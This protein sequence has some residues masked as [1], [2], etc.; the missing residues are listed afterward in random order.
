MEP[1]LIFEAKLKCPVCGNETLIARDY[2]YDAGEVGKL[3][4]SN[5]EC[6][7]CNYKFRD[8]KP[9]ETREPKTLEFVVEKE[10]DLNVMVYRSPFAIV[11]IPE[12]GIEIYPS[13]AS[14]GILSTVEGILEDFLENLGSLCQENDCHDVYEAKEGKRKF[15]LIIEDSSGLSF[16]KSEKVK[17]T[18]SLSLSQ[19]QP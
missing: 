7:S 6:T 3:V 8:V 19:T 9:Y 2:L 18:R 1:K 16:I 11:K 5:W 15:T 13:D 14:Q 12:L 17:V 10:E 4:L